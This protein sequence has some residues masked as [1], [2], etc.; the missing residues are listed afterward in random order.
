M[1]FAFDSTNS[2]L[3]V[4]E[5]SDENEQP[6]AV[7]VYS[8][9]QS[10]GALSQLQVQ[11]LPSGHFPGG[12]VVDN[13]FVYVIDSLS[14]SNASVIYVLPHDATGKVSA[15]VFTQNEVGQALGSG[16]ELQF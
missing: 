1:A 3:Y 10:N 15:P 2:F 9:D 16:A 5:S 14:G 6:Q 7:G 12:M 8:F 4:L 11:P 13:S